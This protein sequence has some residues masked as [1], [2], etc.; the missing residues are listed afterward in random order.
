MLSNTLRLNFSYLKIMLIP[1]QRYHPK[2]IEHILKNKRKNKCIDEII[3]LSDEDFKSL[4]EEFGSKNLKL[5][6]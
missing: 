3:R 4:V 2:V 6:K 5:L 1:L